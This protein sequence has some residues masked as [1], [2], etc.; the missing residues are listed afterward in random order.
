MARIGQTFGKS[1]D[2]V[3][4]A[5]DALNDGVSYMAAAMTQLRKEQQLRHRLGIQDYAA[6]LAIESGRKH[7]DRLAEIAK[8]AAGDETYAENFS[9]GYQAALQTLGLTN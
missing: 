9:A 1:L 2:S 6:D 8:I 5:T 3:C 4:I 7:A